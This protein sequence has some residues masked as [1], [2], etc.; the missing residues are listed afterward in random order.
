MEGKIS[1]VASRHIGALRYAGVHVVYRG[2]GLN[3]LVPITV[4]AVR[5]RV[6]CVPVKGLTL[7]TSK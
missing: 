1:L 4:D 3:S 7:S 5:P 2:W 6:C